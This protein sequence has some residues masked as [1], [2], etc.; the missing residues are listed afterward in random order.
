MGCNNFQTEQT[1]KLVE[2]SLRGENSGIQ[3]C[4]REIREEWERITPEIKEELD[5]ADERWDR[6]ESLNNE[7]SGIE[8][9]KVLEPELFATD[10]KDTGQELS[11]AI[12]DYPKDLPEVKVYTPVLPTK[13]NLSRMLGLTKEH[14]KPLAPLSPWGIKINLHHYEQD[15]K[16]PLMMV[17]EKFHREVPHPKEG[18]SP[19]DRYR[20]DEIQRPKVWKMAARAYL[21]E[22][23]LRDFESAIKE[24]KEKNH[25]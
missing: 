16:G 5:R 15:P 7:Y 11:R 8:V 13:E 10:F 20:Y 19:E 17:E 1:D 4:P 23:L 12:K 24:E 3:S 25:G 9:G 2:A 21:G 18:L 14:G 22:D 6:V